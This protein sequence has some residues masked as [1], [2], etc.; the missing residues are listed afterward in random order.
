MQLSKQ[1][2]DAYLEAVALSKY[3]EELKRS[4]KTNDRVPHFL[5]KL[6]Q[7]IVSINKKLQ[8]GIKPSQVK[9]IVYMLTE[10]F[11]WAV[12]KT[13]NERMLSDAEKTRITKEN[14]KIEKFKEAAE[15]GIVDE[16]F[17]EED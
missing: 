15:T 14:D 11:L 2:H 4:L 6:E 10:T 12:H 7:E 5:I 1:I 9:D 13:A 17:F 16:E 3:P 8:G